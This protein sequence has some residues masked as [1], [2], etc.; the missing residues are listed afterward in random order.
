MSFLHTRTH[1]H[2]NTRTHT[3][4][5]THTHTNTRTHTQTHMHTHTNTRTH[6]HTQTHTHKHTHKHTHTHTHTHTVLKGTSF[7]KAKFSFLKHLEN[8]KSFT[9]SKNQQ[10]CLA[11]RFS[12]AA[13]SKHQFFQS[14][15]QIFSCSRPSRE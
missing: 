13:K 6:T 12:A 10:Q 9:F 11:K 8:F 1:T 4:K 3:H 7:S 14:D 15:P 2:T 5:H